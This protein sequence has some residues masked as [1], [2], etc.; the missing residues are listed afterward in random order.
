MNICHAHQQ[1]QMM[2]VTSSIPWIFLWSSNQV[3]S[4]HRLYEAVTL[5]YYL[6]YTCRCNFLFYLHQTTGVVSL[7]RL[8]MGNF[9]LVMVSY[10]FT[11]PAIFL[12]L[13]NTNY[14]SSFIFFMQQKKN[15]HLI[16]Q[17]LCSFMYILVIVRRQPFYSTFDFNM[18]SCWQ[19]MR[20]QNVHNGL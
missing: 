16:K 14:K 15:E 17:K 2:H 10:L 1:Q 11:F 19:K 13:E 6:E 7:S 9:Y 8:A 20:T 18:V 4:Y 12:R 3:G 5:F